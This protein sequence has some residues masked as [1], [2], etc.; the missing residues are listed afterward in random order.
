LKTPSLFAIGVVVTL[1]A[2]KSDSTTSASTTGTLTKISG[3]S[4]SVVVGGSVTAPLVAQL[5]SS[6]GSPIAGAKVIW[7]VPGGTGVLSDSA[8]I[9][10]ANGKASTTY[11]TTDHSGPVTVN[12]TFESAGVAFTVVQV[13]GRPTSFTIGT[14]NGVAV[15]VGNGVPLTAFV[16]DTLGNGVAG[17]TVTWST[18]G[19][20]LRNVTSTT[21]LDGIAASFITLGPAAGR[22][23]VQAATAGFPTLTYLVDGVSPTGAASSGLSWAPSRSGPPRGAAGLR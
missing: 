8:A 17:V 13:A 20:I 1:V 15:L 9:T 14:G 16:L 2:C 4:Q 21:G 3:D 22:V 12:A 6:S 18:N 19:G 11:T 10:D 5:A 23:T 7:S